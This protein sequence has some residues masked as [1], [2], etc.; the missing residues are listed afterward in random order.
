MMPYDSIATSPFIVTTS[1]YLSDP[2]WL[3]NVVDPEDSDVEVDI[4]HL[5]V[6]RH[7][8]S[9]RNTSLLLIPLHCQRAIFARLVDRASTIPLQPFNGTAPWNSSSRSVGPWFHFTLLRCSNERLPIQALAPQSVVADELCVF[10]IGNLQ[11]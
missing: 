4:E 11:Y 8:H 9:M 2:W 1:C 7:H 5:R 6:H 10:W 3:S